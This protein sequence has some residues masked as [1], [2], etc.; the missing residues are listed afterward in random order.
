[1]SRDLTDL[2]DD[3]AR[4]PAQS[5]AGADLVRRGRRR[6]Q[7]RHAVMTAAP[8]VLIGV[9]L[10]VMPRTSPAVDILDHPSELLPPTV[11]PSP[12]TSTGD[13]SQIVGPLPPPP[14]ADVRL[15]EAAYGD[16]GTAN[17]IA[18]GFDGVWLTHPG[19]SANAGVV[20]KVSADGR[21]DVEAV[22]PVARTPWQV[23]V[24]DT[25]VWIGGPGSLM[26]ID[27][28]TNTVDLDVALDIDPAFLRATSTGLWAVT[29]FP[30]MP[31][32]RRIDPA[33]GDVLV[34]V[35]LD[36]NMGLTGVAVT[37]GDIFVGVAGGDVAAFDIPRPTDVMVQPRIVVD[38]SSEVISLE[39]DT[40]RLWLV[41]TATGDV[42]EFDTFGL[43]LVARW[44][45][46]GMAFGLQLLPDG[47]PLAIDGDAV[48]NQLTADG[49]V[50]TVTLGRLGE[51]VPVMADDEWRIWF[52]GERLG[53]ATLSS[54]DPLN[55]PSTI[56][57]PQACTTRTDVADIDG[58]GRDDVF[59][60]DPEAFELL[61]CLA[62]GSV[63]R[64]DNVGLEVLFAGDVDDDGA[65]EIF[66]GGTTANTAGVE[67]G[68][69]VDGAL[70]KVLAPG[71]DPLQLIEG[72][73]GTSVNGS[74]NTATWGCADMTGDLGD[75][76]VT[77]EARR[78]TETTWEVVTTAYRLDGAT[79]VV[80]DVRRTTTPQTTTPDNYTLVVDPDL[81][82][83]HTC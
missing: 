13:N 10:A 59:K 22:I 80:V 51:T 44:S 69:W 67:M 36:V 52:A 54:L 76:L 42:L 26:R 41:D 53:H 8:L 61:V 33:T 2:L 82:P 39:A 47:T 66:V 21:F 9:V 19:D 70:V 3:T 71:G 23:A 81:P 30:D 56:T 55:Q 1:M 28:A 65:V 64:L 35:D 6:R 14:V 16:Y 31:A 40:Q 34:S 18:V 75:E 68:R 49:F 27:P 77:V 29:A 62:D 48:A 11:A 45:V 20:T 7:R 79:A 46:D 37:N 15:V 83:L 60:V 50:P 38:G 58:D 73:L 78:A 12:A 4:T 25:H 32:V 63:S 5:P 74:T 17:A 24:T 57:D 72:I 43:D